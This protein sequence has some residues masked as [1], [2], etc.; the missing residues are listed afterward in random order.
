MRAH[1]KHKQRVHKG[2]GSG[3]ATLPLLRLNAAALLSRSASALPQPS[4]Q[5]ST[6]RVSWLY[7]RGLLPHYQWGCR[8]TL[9]SGFYVRS[10]T[11]HGFL[12]SGTLPTSSGAVFLLSAFFLSL[13]RSS[14]EFSS[15]TTLVPA[16]DTQR[17][18][19]VCV[20]ACKKTTTG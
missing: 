17:G 15:Q 13:L 12:Y 20:L 18:S 16:T 3:L 8:G 6:L 11:Y 9:F 2:F 14:R 10:Q 5:K 1:N 19:T 4:P 7:F